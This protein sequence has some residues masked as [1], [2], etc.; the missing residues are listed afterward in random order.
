MIKQKLSRALEMG[1]G[2]LRLRPNWVPRAFC[3]PGK[4]LRLHPDDYYAFGGHRGGI[5]ER[6]FAS[7]THADNGPET[8]EDEG[9][10]YICVEDGSNS[11]KI[12]LRDSIDLMGEEILGKD[13]IQKH[14]GWM[15]FSKF[16]DN[17]EPLPHH[18]HQDDEYAG[19]VGE[20]G[21]PEGYYFP[22]QLNNHGGYFP[23]T[24]FGL[25]PGTTK[26]E[27]R[28][29]LEK[30]DTGD[31][32]ILDLSRAYK[33]KL[34]TGW[35]VPPRLLHAP[36]SLLTYEPQRASDVYA[37][38][39]SL[40]W[41]RYIP[42]DLLVKDV[43]Q[44]NK[45]DLDYLV[46]MIDW[47]LNTD[48]DFYSNS[49]LPPK[50]LRTPEEMREEGYEEYWVVYNSD[51]F[52]AKELTLFPERSVTIREDAAYGL[53]VIQGHG[54]Y[55]VLDI[56]AHTMIRFGQMTRDELFVT[57]RAARDGITVTNESDKEDLVILKHFGP[58]A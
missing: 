44:A 49:F 55:G 54:K 8:L 31:N 48:P 58:E 20:K 43:P 4:R 7:T 19:R 27:V 35:I 33:L 40:V 10:S 41:N 34:G 3:I 38:Y 18:L 15:M 24:F 14:G 30:W 32:G 53:I 2:V 36:G 23:F 26:A 6:W 12:L 56:E 16:F 52:S 57:T 17:L 29:C 45:K 37:L 46:E 21:K 1:K 13:I 9:L 39:Q 42:W 11:D 25:N 47:D 5:D 22:K 28:L 50:P 51:D